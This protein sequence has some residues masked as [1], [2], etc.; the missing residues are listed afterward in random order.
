MKNILII[1]F[2]ALGDVVRT[3]YFLKPLYRKYG[4]PFIYWLTSEPSLPLLRFNPY[5]FHLTSNVND[6]LETEFDWIISLDD[7][8]EIVSIVNQLKYKKITGAH[9]KDNK[10]FYTEDSR[11]WFDMGIISRYGKKKADELKKE[12]RLSHTEIFSKILKINNVKPVFYNAHLIENRYGK[13]FENNYFHVGINNS[14]G[15]RWPSKKIN[16]KELVLLINKILSL[17]IDSKNVKIHLLGS[18][19]EKDEKYKIKSLF[20]DDKK[21]ICEDTDESL[22]KFAAVIKACDYIITSDSLALHLAIAQQIPNLSYYAPTSA[23]EI[24]TFGTG[25]KVVST[26]P[27]YCSYK[28]DTDNRTITSERILKSFKEHLLVLKLI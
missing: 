3:S 20:N 19:N 6:L 4:E 25:V 27:D 26:S 10:S 9:P 16:Y 13:N 2:G 23:A 15:K 24:D 18:K 14:A 22:L 11:L 12:N 7:E 28:P 8:L 5:V 21:V 17:K 1:K